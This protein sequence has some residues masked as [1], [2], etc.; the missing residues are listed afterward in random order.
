MIFLLAGTS[1]ARELALALREQGNPLMASVVTDSAAKSLQAAG[2]DVRVGRLGQQAMIEELTRLSVALLVDASHPYAEEAHRTAMAAASECRIPYLRFEREAKEYTGIEG[3]ILVDT[4]AE[5]AEIAAQKKG[6]VMLTT[7]G[8]TLAIFAKRL[9]GDPEIRL[10]VRLL[11]RLDNME[12]CAELGLEQKNIVAMQGPFSQELNSALYKHYGTTLVVTKESGQVGAV[13]EKV[14]AAINMG[15]E[16]VVI[17]RPRLDYG[18]SCSTLAGALNEVKAYLGGSK[19]LNLPQDIEAKS[20]EMIKEELGDHDFT[21]EQFPVVQRVIHASA[22]FELGRSLVFHPDAVKAGI[23]AI[24]VGCATIAD[25]QMVQA[26]ISKPRLQ[27]FGGDV[28]VFIADEDV[29]EAARRESTTR[30]IIA[31]R[32]AVKVAPDGIFV[33]GNAPTALLELLRLVTAGEARP[34]LVVGVPVGF[35]SA[36]ESKAELMKLDIPFIANHGRKGGSPVAVAIINAL[37]I[38]ADKLER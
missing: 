26:G 22:D 17:G 28:R 3:V 7:G 34:S 2:I 4:Y 1:D 27:K 37:S 18:L 8:K 11:P 32:K 19:T 15:I 24:R 31:M 21:E 16:V 33:I 6:S 23:A 9:L 30:A 20:F 14:Q 29:A 13:D 35:V 10:V 36:A 38:M 25:V 5:A 12:K